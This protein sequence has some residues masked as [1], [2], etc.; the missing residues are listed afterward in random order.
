MRRLYYVIPVVIFTVLLIFILACS[1]NEPNIAEKVGEIEI[2]E[3]APEEKSEEPDVQEQVEET[4][5]E[6]PMEEYFEIGDKVNLNGTIVT[7]KGVEKSSGD[8]FDRPKEGMEYVI[9]T[10]N[11]QNG[12]DDT[13]S[14][15]PFDFK[16]Q[17]SNGQITDMAFSIINSDTSMESGELAPGGTVEGTIVFEEPIDDPALILIFQPSFWFDDEVVKIKLGS[18]VPSSETNVVYSDTITATEGEVYS[19]GDKV[20][21]NGTIVTVKEVEKSLG[22]D[23]DEPKEGME[24]VIVTINIQNGSNDTISYN[25]FDFKIQNSNGQI[26]DMA[27][28]IIDSDTALESGELAPG[29]TVEGTIVFEEPI[30][31]PALVLIF[32]P[33]FWFDDEVVKI[34]L[35]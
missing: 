17:N 26:T 34:R 30:D 31:D 21:L 13:I 23:F 24:Y 1:G 8:D 9:V 33:S 20:D 22:N 18:G 14:Y 16:I 25:P 19:L 35:N 4:I 7:V 27:F 2:E 6:E 29:G 10:I 5:E 11:I 12:S 32:Q 28:S 15:N 3:N